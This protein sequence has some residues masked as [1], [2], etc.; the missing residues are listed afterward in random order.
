LVLGGGNLFR[1][2]DLAETG[3]NRVTCDHIGMLATMM[4]GLAMRDTLQKSGVGVRILSSIPILGV[5]EV[6][7]SIRAVD[8]LESGKVVVMIGGTGN[9][10][11]TTDSCACLRAIEVDADL[12]L[13]ATKVDYIFSADPK[14]N[15]D[16]IKYDTI[17]F[18]DVLSQDIRVM[19]HTAICLA[20]DNNKP[21][22]VFNV[23]VCGNIIKAV[24]Q[25]IGTLVHP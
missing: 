12:V 11:F 25:Q 3:L 5:A 18:S 6:F 17:S 2:S 13:K 15:K 4:N 24:N 23:E 1:G 8:H 10:F 19:D 16:A 7:D 9:P 22:R 21:I 20:R 14:I